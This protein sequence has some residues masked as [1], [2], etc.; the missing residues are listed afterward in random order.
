MQFNEHW[1]TC[2]DL[3]ARVFLFLSNSPYFTNRASLNMFLHNQQ[4]RISARNIT[5][6]NLGASQMQIM[7]HAFFPSVVVLA[8]GGMHKTNFYIR[9]RI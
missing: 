3:F 8:I 1:N 5:L 4:N 6:Q 2:R 9:N 7:G